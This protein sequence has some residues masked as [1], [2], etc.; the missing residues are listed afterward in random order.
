MWR[1]SNLRNSLNVVASHI[2]SAGRAESLSSQ[3][4]YLHWIA[5]L[6]RWIDSWKSS[7]LNF[8][9]QKRR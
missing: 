3:L 9:E 1:K 2:L 7:R 5:W 4:L 6:H 8:C